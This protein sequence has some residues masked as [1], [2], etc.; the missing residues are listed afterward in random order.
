MIKKSLITFSLI[1]GCFFA[2]TK[3]LQAQTDESKMDAKVDEILAEMTIEEKIGQLNLLN[4]G[5]GVAT[6]AVVSDNVQQKIKD[7]EVGGLFGVAGPDK[8][9]IAQDYAVNDTRLGIPL[10]IGSDVIH[11]YKTTFPIPLGTAAS[12][13]LEMIKRTA[14]IAAQ[15][16]TADGIN[17]NFSP[18]VD[19][20]RDPR[21]G[22][23]AEGAGEDPYLGS[24]I[25]KAMVEGYQGD[26]LT[27]ENTMIATV[28]HFALYGASEAGRDY[29]TTDMSRVKMFN[30]YL[31]PYKA[32]ID[33]GAG[34]VMSSF[35]DVDGV[36]ATG[37]KWLLTDLL[38]DQWGFDGFVTSDYTSLNEMIAHGMGDLQA[39]SA[40]ALKAGLDMDM[41]G[42]GFLQT[43]KKSLDEGK[44]TEE[45]ITTA[46]RRIL[47]AKYKLGLF[48][49]PYKYLDESRPE[50]DIL[51]EE[52]RAFSRKVAAHS[53]VL[54]KKDAG[55]FPL[56]K[57]AKIALIGP[58]ANNKN[59][60][61]GTWAPTGDPQLSVPVLEGIKNVAPKAKVS[62]AQGANITNDAQL[63]ENINVFG[64]RAEIS[65]TS[66]EKMLEEAIKV[67]KKSDVIVAV[68]GEA[69]EMSGEAAS[70]TN[71][72]IPESQKKMIR[73]L[74]KI[75]KPMALVL[76]SGRPLNISEESEMNLD[77]L[78]VWH[79]GVEAGNAIADVI[80]GDYNPSG[81][82]TASWPRNVGQVP[83]YYSMKRTGRPGSQP[84]FE[85][86]KSEFLDTPNSPLY[87]FGYG[88]SYTDFEYSDVKA[89][90]DEL[91]M[92]GTITLSATITNTGDYDGEEVVQLYIHDKVR[93]IT[94]PMK[95][96]I[97][98]EKIMLKKGESKTVTFEV[99]AEDL[100]FYNSSLEHVAEPGEFDFFIAG[101]SD[102]EFENTFTLKE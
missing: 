34:S 92:D 39:V 68:V 16:A 55:V 94:P 95:Q 77:I 76:M 86:F 38:R 100:K 48:E 62:Y 102:A 27:K 87:P 98:F 59:N 74:A 36:P 66:P 80:F 78:Q 47:E 1:T 10:L 73:E 70:R 2:P 8:I 40:L 6:G 17:W 15:E 30:E 63:A 99:S 5:G 13:D 57:D 71:L 88:L 52:N 9:K 19:I 58:L 97:G 101:S 44:V 83:V 4:P 49:D 93:S 23:I 67:A 29:N 90:A 42:E 81:K 89:S 79:P 45:E 25:A 22:R 32:A 61:L 37:N 46:A 18:M 56:K 64:P 7:G 51:S 28:K 43:L 53:F 24:Q 41:V 65:E 33:A 54:L 84:G 31:P 72:L 3:N 50:K 75:G 82:I 12:W 60:M 11:G 14:E 35:N 69:T 21:W 85:K 96:L 20:A 91:T 26:D